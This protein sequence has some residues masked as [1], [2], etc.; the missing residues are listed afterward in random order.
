M[1]DLSNR[2]DSS[3][4]A[5]YLTRS[6]TAARSDERGPGGGTFAFVATGAADACGAPGVATAAAVVPLPWLSTPVWERVCDVG[7][8]T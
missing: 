8:K 7:L 1:T 3:A 5:A 4:G 2:Q 6:V